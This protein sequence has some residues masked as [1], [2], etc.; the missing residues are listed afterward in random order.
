MFFKRESFFSII[1]FWGEKFFA[2]IIVRKFLL[3]YSISVIQILWMPI[4]LV[5]VSAL[6]RNNMGKLYYYS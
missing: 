6:Q 3:L 1:Y 2:K 5:Q 4:C